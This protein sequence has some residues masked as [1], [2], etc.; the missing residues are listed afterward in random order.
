MTL[1]LSFITELLHPY[2]W[3]FA[4]LQYD[5]EGYPVEEDGWDDD[6][7]DEDFDDFDDMEEEEEELEDDED[8]EEPEWD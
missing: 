1:T 2:A 7:M 5:E 6:D 8:D 4:L 3:S